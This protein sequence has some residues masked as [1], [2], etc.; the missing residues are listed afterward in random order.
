MREELNDFIPKEAVVDIMSIIPSAPLRIKISRER[1]TKFGHY[2]HPLRH[3]ESHEIS[4]NGNLNEYAFLTTLIHE[5]GHM[6]TWLKYGRR[7]KHHGKEWKG[8]FGRLLYEFSQ[9]TYLPDALREAYLRHSRNPKASSV[10]DPFLY[11]TLLSYD[12]KVEAGLSFVKDIPAGERFQF[13]GSKFQLDVVRRSRVLCTNV[14]NQRQYLL[15]KLVRVQP[16]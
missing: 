16:L 10:S 11:E 9:K 7:A 3:G 8:L 13:S 6:H 1:K 5:L 4:V 14:S 12:E 15:H 2:R